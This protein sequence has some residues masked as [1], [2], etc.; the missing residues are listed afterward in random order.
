M[1]KTTIENQKQKFDDEL[2]SLV[3][4]LDVK[5]DGIFIFLFSVFSIPANFI[6][7]G[8][9]ANKIKSYKRFN[10]KFEPKLKH[11][12]AANC[13]N[14]YFI[15]ICSFDTVICLHLII[16]GVFQH[17]NESG[18]TDFESIF[19]V[20]QFTCKFFIYSLHI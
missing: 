19:D 13:F 1:N 2:N 9:F 16:D 10:N 7:L 6:L 11:V 3:S 17:L 4:R 5:S 12:Y 15:E 18:F 20:S 8:F 14:T